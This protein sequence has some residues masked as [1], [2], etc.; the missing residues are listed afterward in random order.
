MTLMIVDSEFMAYETA[1][2]TGVNAYQ[3]TGLYRGL[4]GSGA[5]GHAAGASIARLD[6]AVFKYVLPNSYIG[7]PL[8]L[9]FQSFNIF[10]GG[11][12]DLSDCAAYTFSPAGA[13]SADPI[14]AQ[15]ASGLP[16]DL[17]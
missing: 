2:L 11:L 5:V 14:A 10:G 12:Q 6:G 1:T 9:K 15:L 17:G 16:T 7:Q 8:Y 3:L 13:G 4:Y